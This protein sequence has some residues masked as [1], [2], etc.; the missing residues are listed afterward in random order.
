MYTQRK[1]GTIVTKGC[2]K[3]PLVRAIT[4][5]FSDTLF[6][7]SYSPNFLIKNA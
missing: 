1:K 2:F 5:D 4:Y 3:K 6:S 7:D